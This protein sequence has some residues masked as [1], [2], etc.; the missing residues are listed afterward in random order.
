MAVAGGGSAQTSTPWPPFLTQPAGRGGG[1]GRRWPWPTAAAA[2]FET[3]C[4]YTLFSARCFFY[5][6]EP[7][8]L[9]NPS[10]GLIFF[11][12]WAAAG[13]VLLLL[14]SGIVCPWL[15]GAERNEYSRVLRVP[16]GHQKVKR[17]SARVC[18][19]KVR[20]AEVTGCE[21]AL[22]TT[23]MHLACELVS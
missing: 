17:M 19:Q 23:D 7:P 20:G 4:L 15:Q 13:A 1:G 5:F 22:Q 8:G 9:T 11:F 21:N 6:V 3:F 2:V 18:H 10:L 12:H 14:C 16:Q